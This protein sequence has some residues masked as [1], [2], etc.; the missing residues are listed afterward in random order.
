MLTEMRELPG[1]NDL[2]QALAREKK[3]NRVELAE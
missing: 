2:T 1:N 3:L